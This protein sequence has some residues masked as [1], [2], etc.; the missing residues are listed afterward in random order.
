M[1]WEGLALN[2][3]YMSTLLFFQKLKNKCSC[4]VF[5]AQIQ[6]SA[7]LHFKAGEVEGRNLV[8]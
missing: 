3:V 1:T 7:A 6:P 2:E 5:S 8:S 4:F